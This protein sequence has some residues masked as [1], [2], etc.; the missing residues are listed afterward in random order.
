MLTVAALRPGKSHESFLAALAEIDP[1]PGNLDWQWWIVGA[2]P[3]QKYLRDAVAASP[4]RD[5]IR[6]FGYQPDPRPLLA[7]ADLFVLPSLEESLPNAIIEAQACGLAAL[8]FDVAGLGEC[9]EN[10]ESGQLVPRGDFQRLAS[11]ALKLLADDE[12][13][14]QMAE[15]AVPFALKRFDPESRTQEFLEHITELG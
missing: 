10:K 12:T 8:A 7:T 11:A 6:L 3:R 5:R 15:A 13:R 1:P 2:G 14:N 4:H 9:I